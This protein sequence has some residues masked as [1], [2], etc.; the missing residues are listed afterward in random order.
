MIYFNL[1]E[2][3][4]RKYR[5]TLIGEI[6][7]IFLNKIRTLGFIVDLFIIHYFPKM[8][9][10]HKKYSGNNSVSQRQNWSATF[11]SHSNVE[12]ELKRSFLWG[13]IGDKNELTL[14]YNELLKKILQ[15]S[16]PHAT[17]LELGGLRWHVD[18]VFFISRKNNLC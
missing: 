1:I 2:E 8:Y 9:T 6:G 13:D 18:T 10:K 15:Y 4:N 16:H 11:N 17:V 14:K 3:F 5:N 7:K 12:Y